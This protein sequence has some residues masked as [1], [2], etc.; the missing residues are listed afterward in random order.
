[1]KVLLLVVM[2]FIGFAF[3]F[4]QQISVQTDRTI[5]F[6]G[7]TVWFKAY[8]KYKTAFDEDVKNLY[9]SSFSNVDGVSRI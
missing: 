7:D 3:S 6:P 2:M 5:Y 4:G 8:L 9:F 1:M